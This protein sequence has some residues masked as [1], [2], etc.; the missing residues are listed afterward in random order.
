MLTKFEVQLLHRLIVHL[1]WVQT[2]VELMHL[3]CH[4]WLRL[5]ADAF[6]WKPPLRMLH[7][8]VD[9]SASGASSAGAAGGMFVVGYERWHSWPGTNITTRSC[10]HR[11]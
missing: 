8:D 2:W 9:G 11:C 4:C 5:Q 6:Y 7:P 10:S 1:E 3:S